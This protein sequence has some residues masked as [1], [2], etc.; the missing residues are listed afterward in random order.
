MVEIKYYCVNVLIF[1]DDYDVV[2]YYI[3]VVEFSCDGS[4]YV[5][6]FDFGMGLVCI[7]FIMKYFVEEFLFY[8]GEQLFVVY[9][10]DK[11]IIMIIF[12][13]VIGQVLKWFGFGGFYFDEVESCFWFNGLYG[14][15]F[16]ECSFMGII[17]FGCI[18]YIVVIYC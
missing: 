5:W 2:D 1:D 4:F 6:I 11:K 18:E 3:W 13:V 14:V 9:I 15:N 8:V 16:E 10:G 12:D 17:M 7:G